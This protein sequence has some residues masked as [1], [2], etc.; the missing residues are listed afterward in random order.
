MFLLGCC[1]LASLVDLSIDDLRRVQ[2]GD[3]RIVTF[4]NR[5][6]IRVLPVTRRIT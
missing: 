5:L 1:I 2:L 6:K 3:M 4:R